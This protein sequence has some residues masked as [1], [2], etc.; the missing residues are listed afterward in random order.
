M[1]FTFEELEDLNQVLEYSPWNIKVSPL[2]L[3][4]WSSMDAIEDLDFTKA[5]YWVQCITCR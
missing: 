5:A 3:L 1:V 4:Q 2:F